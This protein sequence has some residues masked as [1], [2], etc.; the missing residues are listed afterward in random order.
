MICVD[1]F[2]CVKLFPSHDAKR[3]QQGGGLRAAPEDG[4]PVSLAERS[5]Q[6]KDGSFTFH[7]A[8]F[9]RATWSHNASVMSDTRPVCDPHRKC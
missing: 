9:H 5:R 1:I 7:T 8:P 6:G 3:A 4:F 2:L